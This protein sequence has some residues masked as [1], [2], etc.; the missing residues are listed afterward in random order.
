MLARLAQGVGELLVLGHGLG[1]L[2]LGLQ[3]PLF[4]G[5]DPLG[6]VLELAAEVDHLLLQGLDLLEH[7][8]DLLLVGGQAALVLRAR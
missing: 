2:A 6:G 8:A 1:Q 4:E 7:D 5:A 3:Q